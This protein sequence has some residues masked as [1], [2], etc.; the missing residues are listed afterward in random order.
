MPASFDFTSK[1]AAYRSCLLEKCRKIVTSLTPAASA[2]SLVVVPRKPFWAKSR[3]AVLRICWRTSPPG[4]YPA[5]FGMS[6]AVLTRLDSLR[7]MFFFPC[8]RVLACK[9]GILL[10]RQEP[11]KR[12]RGG[13]AEEHGG[14]S[15]QL[16]AFMPVAAPSPTGVSSFTSR[17]SPLD[18]E[19]GHPPCVP[20]LLPL[21]AQ[22][23]LRT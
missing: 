4:R 10:S 11:V 22:A 6:P 19:G 12:K 9:R 20:P 3:I 23:A 15:H 1:I 5:P 13:E 17:G 21:R 2:I 18:T 14:C 16:V 7:D 8:K